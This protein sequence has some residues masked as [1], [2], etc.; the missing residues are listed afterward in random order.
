MLSNRAVVVQR[1]DT[2][3]LDA[4]LALVTKLVP[5]A[6]PGHV[7]VHITLRPVHPTD[8]NIKGY[9]TWTSGSFTPGPEGFGIVH[10]VAISIISFLPFG[11]KL[12]HFKRLGSCGCFL[13]VALVLSVME[14]ILMNTKPSTNCLPSHT[15][16]S[17][18]LLH[19]LER[20]WREWWKGKEWWCFSQ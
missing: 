12:G 19:R 17:M 4:G 8:L 20:E 15:C 14:P 9:S 18:W 5:E 1:F 16:F 7:V 2:E 11:C 10:E 6:E 13:S 3:N